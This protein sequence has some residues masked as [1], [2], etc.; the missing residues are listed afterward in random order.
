MIPMTTSF[1]DRLANINPE[2]AYQVLAPSST[3]AQCA[4]W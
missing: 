4:T 3:T 2:G 1:A